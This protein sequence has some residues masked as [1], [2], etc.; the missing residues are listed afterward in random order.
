MPTCNLIDIC[1]LCLNIYEINW[2]TN[3]YKK[4]ILNLLLE[5][6]YKSINQKFPTLT[7]DY[8][9]DHIIYLLHLMFTIKIY[10]SYKEENNILDVHINRENPK[11]RILQ[12]NTIKYTYVILILI[13]FYYST[14][15]ETRSLAVA[16]MVAVFVQS[17][18]S[19]YSNVYVS[20]FIYVHI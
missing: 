8:C 12:Y 19:K 17:G 2:H 1:K 20:L 5:L 15:S 14:A 13:I 10:K 7:I 18:G 9:Q 6:S 4:G 11:L 3:K 16:R